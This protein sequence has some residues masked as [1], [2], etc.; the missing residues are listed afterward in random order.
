MMEKISE[1]KLYGRKWD[2]RLGKRLFLLL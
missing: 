1:P 2:L